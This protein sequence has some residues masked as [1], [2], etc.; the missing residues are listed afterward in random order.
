MISRHKACITL[1]DKQ[2]SLLFTH[3]YILKFVNHR[4][5]DETDELVTKVIHSFKKMVSTLD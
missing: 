5:I 4:V 3:N 2:L 1:L